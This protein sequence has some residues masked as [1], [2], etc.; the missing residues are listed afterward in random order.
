MHHHVFNVNSICRKNFGDI[1]VHFDATVQLV[2]TYIVFVKYL[3]EWENKK[4]SVSSLQILSNFMFRDRNEVLYNIL[5][6]FGIHMNLGR[7]MK[8]CLRGTSSKF[9]LGNICLAYIL[10]GIF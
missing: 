8:L 5:I 9:W 2:N 1:S 4:Q 3:K 6:L 7:L 10:I